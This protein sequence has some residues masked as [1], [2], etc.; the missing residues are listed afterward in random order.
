MLLAKFN[1]PAFDVNGTAN[2]SGTTV[3]QGDVGIGNVTPGNSFDNGK[4]FGPWR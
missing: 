2:I 4:S 3:F 1:A